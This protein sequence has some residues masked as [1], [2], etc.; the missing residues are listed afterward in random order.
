[1]IFYIHRDARDVLVSCSYHFLNIWENLQPKLKAYLTFQHGAYVK[2]PNIFLEKPFL[3]LAGEAWVTH[4]V[5]H[6][7]LFHKV[8]KQFFFGSN[9]RVSSSICTICYENLWRNTEDERRR[10]Y[11]FLQLNPDLAEPLS[12]SDFTFTGFDERKPDPPTVKV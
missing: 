7:W 2:N 5:H 11:S 9:T 6:W 4:I 1:M 3:R 12:T 8:Y 10:P